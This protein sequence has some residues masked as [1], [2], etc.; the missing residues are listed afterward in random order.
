[1]EIFANIYRDAQELLRAEAADQIVEGLSSLAAL[2]T[3]SVSI[4]GCLPFVILWVT[5]GRIGAERKACAFSKFQCGCQSHPPAAEDT[6]A[7]R[8]VK[9]R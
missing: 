5:W 9:V 2:V 6:L 3:P 4:H 7:G 1:M 8:F